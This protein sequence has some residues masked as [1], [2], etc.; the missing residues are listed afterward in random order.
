MSTK[1]S[2]ETK[3][4]EAANLDRLLKERHITNHSKF[5][6]SLKPKRSRA[7]LHQHLNADRP[8]S[9]SAVRAY[10]KELKCAIREISPRWADEIGEQSIATHTSDHHDENLAHTSTEQNVKEPSPQDPYRVTVAPAAVT[11][12]LPARCITVW[13][14]LQALPEVQREIWINE[15]SKTAA[16][17]RLK[18]LKS[19]L[20][21]TRD[22]PEDLTQ[23]QRQAG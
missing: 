7:E 19:R 22:P 14:D 8:I 16:D 10:A 13:E 1:V 5:A 21:R 2:F 20:E 3:K 23:K 18:E 17:A 11:L 4:L 15:L 6:A 12:D 9:L